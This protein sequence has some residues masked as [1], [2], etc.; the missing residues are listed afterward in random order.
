[1]K[2]NNK[3]LITKFTI[4]IF[5]TFIFNNVF[6]HTIDYSFKLVNIDDSQNSCNKSNDTILFISH[7]VT[8]T[9]FSNEVYQIKI[10]VKSIRVDEIFVIVRNGSI[11]KLNKNTYQLIPYNSNS[12]T[13]AV[14]EIISNGEKEPEYHLHIFEKTYKVVP[15]ISY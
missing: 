11:K 14:S 15:Q 5:F 10:I 2:G 8:D 9:L 7:N 3:I 4:I 6:N 1:M 13:I 12:L